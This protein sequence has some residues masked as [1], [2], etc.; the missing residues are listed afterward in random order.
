M[1]YKLAP[2]SGRV[3]RTFTFTILIILVAVPTL[4]WAFAS[5]VEREAQPLEIFDYSV[6]GVECHPADLPRLIEGYDCGDTAIEA[7]I[8]S[9]V[10]D[11]EHTINRMHR[12]TYLGQK[13]EE[14]VWQF[15]GVNVMHDPMANNTSLLGQ[16]DE[17]WLYVEVRA[18]GDGAQKME[19]L[20]KVWGLYN[21]QPVPELVVESIVQVQ[22]LPPKE[23]V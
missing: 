10:E 5:T 12:V 16:I 6:E 21:D 4:T 9:Q 11:P 1:S 22:P 13:P 19:I 20:E 23:M 14:P 2:A 15:D 18:T 7:M 17:Q 8:F 3:F